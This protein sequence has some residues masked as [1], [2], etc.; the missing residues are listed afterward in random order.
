MKLEA[1]LQQTVH[2]AA[3]NVN[4][5]P[6]DA[7]SS[8][9]VAI[10]KAAARAPA[11]LIQATMYKLLCA[12]PTNFWRVLHMMC[13]SKCK[14][15]LVQGFNKRSLAEAGLPADYSLADH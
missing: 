14:T 6:S 9:G 7:P 1:I 11:I 13:E 12:D 2:N 3:S 5:L 4:H 8:R 10:T 15:T